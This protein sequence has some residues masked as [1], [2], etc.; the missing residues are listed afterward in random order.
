MH[1][2]ANCGRLVTSHYRTVYL[3]HPT[4]KDKKITKRI[5]ED[6]CSICSSIG[7]AAAKGEDWRYEQDL[8][9][10]LTQ[11]GIDI[12]DPTNLSVFSD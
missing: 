4:N 7:D 9:D 6:L 2:K 10:D 1:C 3:P 12:N 5:P 11:L 8:C